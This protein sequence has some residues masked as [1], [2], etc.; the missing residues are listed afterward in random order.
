MATQLHEEVVMPSWRLAAEL[1]AK[2]D[3]P[4]FAVNQYRYGAVK[5]LEELLDDLVAWRESAP[6]EPASEFLFSCAVCR[7]MFTVGSALHDASETLEGYRWALDACRLLV[8]TVSGDRFVSVADVEGCAA[9]R[10]KSLHV[11]PK[12]DD[13]F[14][15]PR[16]TLQSGAG[17]LLELYLFLASV[18]ARWNDDEV[19]TQLM[20]VAKRIVEGPTFRLL[21]AGTQVLI[22][23]AEKRDAAA[24]VILSSE[25]EAQS[26]ALALRLEAKR[27]AKGIQQQ[28]PAGAACGQLPLPPVSWMSWRGTPPG[29]SAWDAIQSGAMVD[30]DYKRNL[31][32]G[33]YNCCAQLLKSQSA[34]QQSAYYCHKSLRAKAFSDGLNVAEWVDAA[35]G[36]VDWYLLVMDLSHAEHCLS[37]ARRLTEL[38][39]TAAVD[40]LTLHYYDALVAGAL[41]QLVRVT[42]QSHDGDVGRAVAPLFLNPLLPPED[43][44]NVPSAVS[45]PNWCEPERVPFSIPGV[46]PLRKEMLVEWGT[47][48]GAE[49]VHGLLGRLRSAASLCHEDIT[50]DTD[51]ERYLKLLRQ[52]SDGLSC[53]YATSSPPEVSLLG[54]RAVVLKQILSCQLNPLAFRN[55][56][57]QA[58]YEL[59]C[60]LRD[61]ALHAP[62]APAVEEAA[63][64]FQRFVAGFEAEITAAS[65]VGKHVDDV[66]EVSDFPSFAVGCM[67][68]GMLHLKMK[69]RS[70]AAALFQR[71]EA[72]LRGNPVAVRSYPILAEHMAQCHEMLELLGVAVSVDDVTLT[73]T[74]LDGM[75]RT[76]VKG[77]S[78]VKATR[79]LGGKR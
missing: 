69:K 15:H 49:I 79:P 74:A 33:V 50:L 34:L 9:S 77:A 47:P 22:D 5:H 76:T 23:D 68:L 10:K 3:S 78:R 43:V 63:L 19:A 57:R 45:E 61:I 38:H 1:L 30:E 16:I 59:G 29:V 13:L 14:A 11:A 55:V 40:S 71:L 28:P 7:T 17:L 73:G 44:R 72:F 39:P 46:L 37:A 41:L 35:L 62:G 2:G 25:Q 67:Q 65:K 6:S 27:R 4:G 32:C 24:L 51:C 21:S 20:N 52:E 70:E 48:K 56:I 64:Y 42:K 18:W 58:E 66:F 8:T 12:P 60:T 53:A 75:A 54:E 36:L 26:S 31:V